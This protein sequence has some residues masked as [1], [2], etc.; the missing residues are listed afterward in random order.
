MVLNPHL[1]FLY[2]DSRKMK[3][4]EEYTNIYIYTNACM[5]YKLRTR[6]GDI[7]KICNSNFGSTLPCVNDRFME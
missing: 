2:I 1:Y 4:F 3:V 5:F 7:V 6:T